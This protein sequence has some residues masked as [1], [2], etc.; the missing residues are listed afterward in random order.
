MATTEISRRY[1]SALFNLATEN[2]E[3]SGVGSGLFQIA[4]A[5]EKNAEFKNFAS[6]PLIRDQ[7]KE[8]T[9]KTLLDSHKLDG[10]TLRSFVL[11]LAKKGRVGLLPEIA[12]CF[13]NQKDAA[14][15]IS[16][17]T[18]RTGSPLTPEQRMGLESEI[19]RITGKSVQ[20][21]Y[22]NDATLVGGL[23]VKVGSLTF[24][25][26]VQSHLKRM[27]EDLNRSIH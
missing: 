3:L 22:I 18:V 21:D 27:K 11:L 7:E 15:K 17:G 13:A 6:S 2:N 9:L 26:S 12:K 10:N 5:L 1:A 25:D 14:D 19:A 24:D 4:D 23:V 8:A 20:L 16:R